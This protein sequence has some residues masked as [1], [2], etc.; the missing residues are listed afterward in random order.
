MSKSKSKKSSGDG[1][2]TT[3]PRKQ[4]VTKPFVDRLI[5]KAEVIFSRSA[6][7]ALACEKRGVSRE[8]V[9]DARVFL[10]AAETYREIF[11]GLRTS[12]WEPARKSV[13]V[14]IKKGDKVRVSSKP[15]ILA[16]YSYL[17][18]GATTELV[19]KEVVARGKSAEVL[20]AT[21]AGDQVCG[22]IPRN[23]LILDAHSSSSS[24]TD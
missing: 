12:G 17:P 10:A 19:A 14:E 16:R 22:Y 24:R 4:R 20:V 3:G 8:I 11:F 1:A 2:G 21:A 23:H 5:A 6:E 9:D 7:I 15:E 13:S 18:G